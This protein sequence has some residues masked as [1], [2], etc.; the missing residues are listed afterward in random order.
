MSGAVQVDVVRVFTDAAGGLGNELGVIRQ[1]PAGREQ[2][3]TAVLG[4]SESVFVSGIADGVA[5]MRIFTPAG[6]LPFAGHPCVGAAWWAASQ[7][8]PLVALDVAAGRVA[9]RAD[10]ELTWIAGRAEWTPDFAFSELPDAAA[11]DAL[12]PHAF[13]EGTH[14]LWATMPD[15]RLRAR[16]FAR[17]MGILEDQ[18][19]GAA[20]VRLTSVL[21]RDLA[22]V[23]GLGAELF[24]RVLP[25]GF[26][27][28][29][30]RTAFD[31]ALEL[32]L[33]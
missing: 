26:V 29:G 33:P 10:G 13:T 27:E 14:Y 17:S 1:W 9:V 6:E 31:R 25:D 20:A 24:T 22:I 28:V 11:V 18:A 4:F 30:G 21:G 15:G 3:I 19:T 23:Q 8:T 5:S 16:M 7:G 32:P 2:E 12:D